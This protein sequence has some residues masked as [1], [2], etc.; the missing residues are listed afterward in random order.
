VDYVTNPYNPNE[1]SARIRTHIQLKAA[2]EKM[3]VMANKL[4]KYL[5]PEVYNSIFT[6]QQDVRIETSKKLLTVCFTDIVQFTPQAENMT[7]EELTVWLN[8]YMN[9]MAEITLKYGGTLDKF[10]GDAVMV[11]FGD[12]KTNGGRQD[13]IAC[14]SMAKAMVA[15]AI[16][17][18][19]KIRVGINS[20][21]CIVGNFGS[22]NRMDYTI[23]GK[24]VN[25]AHRLESSAAPGRIL[26]SDTTFQ[27][28]K[29][30]IPCTLR[31]AI[32]V[33]G[34]ERIIHTHWVK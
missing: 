26:I 23:I 20:G 3:K 21:E 33:K 28:V 15:E 7:N 32:Q 31:G 14:V 8:N 1:L 25:I 34:I 29:D 16:K 17:L 11:F 22:E 30:Q 24:E 27:L 2:L 6:G 13:A 5:S 19:I 10:I 4:G 18:N 9:R 12:P